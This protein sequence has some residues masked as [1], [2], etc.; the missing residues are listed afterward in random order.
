MLPNK[1]IY[2]CFVVILVILFS[3]INAISQDGK[4]TVTGGGVQLIVSSLSQC[5]DG[6][7]LTNWSRV[8]IKYTNNT[9]DLDWQLRVES[10]YSG[11]QS[12][13]SSPEL[14]LDYLV[15]IPI[16]VSANGTTTN[17]P[18]GDFVLL[19]EPNGNVLI[20]GTGTDEFD[21]SFGITYQFGMNAPPSLMN[22]PWGYYFSNLKFVLEYF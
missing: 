18:L 11:F 22:V 15:L 19:E 7:Q 14:S 17:I 4:L 9:G 21:V 12:D 3:P 8:T 20:E 5:E 6:V 16:N 10:L 1:K 13:G 2:G